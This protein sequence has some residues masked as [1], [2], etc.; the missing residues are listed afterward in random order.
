MRRRATSG[1]LSSPLMAAAAAAVIAVSL[2]AAAMPPR[3]GARTGS[4]GQPAALPVVQINVS[5]Q[6]TGASAPYTFGGWG[7]SLAWWAKAAG[8]WPQDQQTTLLQHLFGAPDISNP[9]RSLGLTVARYNISASSLGSDPSQMTC[10]GGESLVSPRA[11][12][13]PQQ[14]PG[15]PVQPGRD[16]A[17][18][19][20]FRQID[21]M[22]GSGEHEYEAFANSP[23]WWLLSPGT[24]GSR[25]PTGI[26]SLPASSYGQYA[27]YLTNVL[28]AFHQQ[29]HIDFTSVD[30]F[31]EPWAPSFRWP[32]GC[33]SHCQEGANFAPTVP[34]GQTSPQH[35][36]VSDLCTDLL[37]SPDLFTRTGV[38]ATDENTPGGTLSDYNTAGLSATCLSQVNTHGYGGPSQRANVPQ[39]ATLPY[40]VWMSEYGNNGPSGSA[41]GGLAL[42]RQIALDLQY[43]R[44]SA[45]VYWQ[46]VEAD[47]P[48]NWGLFDDSN[49]PSAPPAGWPGNTDAAGR[50]DAGYTYRYYALAQYSPFIRPGDIM[51]KATRPGTSQTFTVAAEDPASGTIVLVTTNCR[52]SSENVATG[53]ACS[54]ATQDRTVQYNL[55]NLAA[56]GSSVRAWR[57]TQGSPLQQ[58]DTSGMSLS[59]GVLTDP[60]QPAGSITTYVI[61]TP[62]LPPTGGPPG[63]QLS[64]TGPASADYHDPFTASATLTSGGS[65]LPGQAVIFRLATAAAARPARQSPPQQAQRAAHLPRTRSRAP[66]R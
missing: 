14:G 49:F 21:S 31:N 38:S 5:G 27:Q 42:A 32:S 60:S 3:D 37:D 41:D 30:P 39:L 25:C 56:D 22:I 58:I 54:P 12:P 52:G 2:T 10:T 43:L 40:P 35:Q 6:G 34:P 8:S 11:V 20:I 65:P 17:Q 62:G 4:A 1:T 66:P 18:L 23:P 7:T 57:T 36:I 24:G 55:G 29:E 51:L 13:V 64:Y 16:S 63:T 53:P 15:S 46:A 28:E 33:T 50:T 47:S 45:W 61:Q 59:G 9:G 48:G 19:S 44:P 26:D